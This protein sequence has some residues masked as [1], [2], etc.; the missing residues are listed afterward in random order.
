MNEFAGTSAYL[1][2]GA[3]VWIAFLF[4]LMIFS[5]LA[6]DN[7]VSR[8]AQHILIG[9]SLGYAGVLAI[10]HV[11]MPRLFAPIMAGDA[12]FTSTWLPLALGVILL[13]AA[14]DRM[15]L[16]GDHRTA[17]IDAWR[18][19][20]HG[21][22]RLVVAVLLGIGLGAGVM[23]ALQGTFIPQYL[24]AAQ[25]GFSADASGAGLLA[26]MFTLLLTSAVLLQLFLDP[27]RHLSNQPAYVRNFM[28]SWLWV[29]QRALWFASGLIFARLVA[30][31]LS[32]LIARVLF[33]TQ[34]VSDSPVWTWLGNLR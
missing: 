6:G 16:Q 13:L 18:R 22:G 27:T 33:L 30:S 17:P 31:R 34:T 10:R 9:A 20:L 15:R 24:R 23:G 29:G 19:A 11:L 26:G 4:T 12:T 8:L 5:A 28:G 25:T 7:G 14:L 1:L 32:L 21:A 3:G 2:N